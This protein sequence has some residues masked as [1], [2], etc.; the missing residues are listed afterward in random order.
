MK[1][2][3][4]SGSLVNAEEKEQAS[5]QNRADHAEYYNLQTQVV[6]DDCAAD[7]SRKRA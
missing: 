1:E 4:I 6:P 5:G 2:F 7:N 3:N